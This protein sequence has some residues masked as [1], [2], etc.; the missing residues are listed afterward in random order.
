[1]SDAR[2]AFGANRPAPTLA[3]VL[4]SL[5]SASLLT[6]CA[7]TTDP[8]DPYANTKRNAMIGAAAGAIAG[9]FVGDG[10]LDEV[11][12]TA[13]VGAGLGAGV[14]VYMDKQQRQLE[15]IEGV[16][17]ERVDE[18]TV[19]VSFD[20]D[21]LFA[22][23]SSIVSQAS[24]EDLDEFAWVMNEYP[25]TAI[26]IQG[27]TDSTGSEEYNQRLS[28]RRA[29]AVMNYLILADVD[30][31][32]MDAIGYGEAHPVADNSTAQ[33]RQLNRRV[34]ILVRGKS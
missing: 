32:R 22:V 15:Q 29:Q 17:V 7:T 19:R 3:L 4:S 33:G 18:E 12:G 8:N 28:E 13:A 25:K 1:M 27:H 6:A 26:L 20:G 14:G 11:L 24:M 10:E 34:S 16:D 30:A 5:L 23:D 2:Q 31:S 9:L 21:I